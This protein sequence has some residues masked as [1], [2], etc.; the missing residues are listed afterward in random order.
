MVLRG[1]GTT[2]ADHTN[3]STTDTNSQDTKHRYVSLCHTV[4]VW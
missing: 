4:E 1:T 3:I 2:S